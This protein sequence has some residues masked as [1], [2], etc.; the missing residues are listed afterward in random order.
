M[1]RNGS[2]VYS[3]PAGN[4]V[5]AGTTISS[6]TQNS[7]LTDIRDA[8][9]ASLAKDGQ[10]VPTANLPMGGFRH[11]GV[12]DAAARNEY[13]TADQVQDGDLLR[14]ASVS[15][16]DTITATLSPAITGYATGMMVVLAPAG[17][18]TT[19]VT[20]NINGVGAAAVIMP[21]GNACLPGELRVGL[22]VIL[23]YNGASWVFVSAN[24]LPV[25]FTATLTGVGGTVTGTAVATRIGRM[26]MLYLPGL[27]G[28]SNSTSMT[29]T[30]LPAS[31]QSN[32]ASQR[33][34]FS[35][36]IDNGVISSANI[37][38]LIESASP[39]IITFL[40]AGSATGWTAAGNK[41]FYGTTIMYQL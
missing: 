8:I 9:T 25:S 37:D 36:S 5:V 32:I 26:V 13:A 12:S 1:P 33:V 27:A 40:L 14:L 15:G 39:S 16:V 31:I 30:G 41:G 6:A 10:T 24:Q 19:G 17:T 3:L 29:V 7:T 21:D 11:T 4:P 20:L 35:A 34:A 2:G 23:I 38:A 22:Q 28:T 18:N